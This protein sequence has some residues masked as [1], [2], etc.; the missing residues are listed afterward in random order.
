[1]FLLQ[2]AAVVFPAHFHALRLKQSNNLE[3]LLCFTLTSNIYSLY[4][5]EMNSLNLCPFTIGNKIMLFRL[6]SSFSV[7]YTII[8]EIFY[9]A[10]SHEKKIKKSICDGHG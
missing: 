7:K 6:L 1:M 2:P 9:P 3:E 4:P 5:L 8:I 10:L